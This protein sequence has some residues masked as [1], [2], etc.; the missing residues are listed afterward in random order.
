MLCRYHRAESIEAAAALQLQLRPG[1]V[2]R[3]KLPAAAKPK[4][5]Q[6]LES[7]LSGQ[8]VDVTVK[9]APPPARVARIEAAEELS[10]L[11][12]L[13]C[14]AQATGMADGVLRRAQEMVQVRACLTLP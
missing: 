4:E 11:E 9:L 2:L 1:D 14:Y 13:G 12:L 7:Q 5:I 10:P 6:A 8:G 3:I